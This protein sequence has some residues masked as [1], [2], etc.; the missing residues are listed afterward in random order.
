MVK[1]RNSLVQ[2]SGSKKRFGFGHEFSCIEY[3][4]KLEILLCGTSVDFSGGSSQCIYLFYN[5]MDVQRHF[6]VI[7]SVGSS[8]ILFLKIPQHEDRII[9]VTEKGTLL[10][11]E[12]S[13]ENKKELQT[14]SR[15]ILVS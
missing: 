7:S 13:K 3:S 2:L 8:P 4:K 9:S 15:C 11:Y 12:I 6:N 1:D 5:L 14:D 10:R